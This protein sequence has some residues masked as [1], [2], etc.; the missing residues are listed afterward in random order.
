M[1]ENNDD[2]NWYLASKRLTEGLSDA[3]QLEWEV[4]LRNEKFKNDF[5]LIEKHW[6]ALEASAYA[7]IN[8]GEDW[9]TVLAKIRATQQ[10]AKQSVLTTWLR[11]AAMLAFVI[12][13]AYV[14]WTFSKPSTTQTFLTRI[15][16]PDGARTYVTLPDSS[17]VWLNAGSRISF[18]QHFGSDNRDLALEGEAFFDVE[19]SKVPFKVQTVAYEISVLGTAFNVKAYRDDDEV[20]TTLIRGSLKV[21]RVNAAG[22]A[23]EILIRP[24]EKLT[25]HALPAERGTHPLELQKNIDGAAEAD[26]KD[27]WLT[28]RGESLRGLS[29]KIERLYNVTIQFEDESLKAY[30]YTGRIQQFSLE[31][32]LT[33]LALTS[34]IEFEIHEKSV[35][36]RENK[37]TKSKYQTSPTP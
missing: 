7:K 1:E 31:Q 15:E 22:V 29:K 6:R 21:N 19:K 5:A 30:K 10:P 27:G 2:R 13:S 8:V 35:T 24:N 17:H 11:Y 36:L 9:Q 34:P 23:E 14:A 33:A 25:L 18:D 26:W 32:V 16:A 12:V 4:V 3:E 20:S 28:V 37:N